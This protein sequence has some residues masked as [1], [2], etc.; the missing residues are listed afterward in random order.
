MEINVL[1]ICDG[2]S[3]GRIAL[4]RA[5][6]KVGNYYASEIDKYAIQVTQANYPDTIQ[7]GDMTGWRD[8]DIDWKSIGMVQSGTPCQGFS[9]AGKQ[10]AFDDPRSKLFFVFVEIL[11]HVQS[12]NPS[13]LFLLENVRMKEEH[14]LVISRTLGINPIVI[15]SAL[16]SAQSRLRLYW[17]NFGLVPDGMF[18]EMKIG[19]PQPK[20]KG[21]L[22]RDVLESEVEEKY[23]LSGKAVTGILQHKQNQEEKG[24][25]FGAVIKG[26]DDLVKV[27]SYIVASRG[28]NPENPSDITTGASLEQRL[29][30]RTDGKTN[31][32]T[33]VQKDN[34]VMQLNPSKESN[35]VQPYQQNRVY[36]PDGISPALSA[37]L[38]SG[39]HLIQVGNIYDNEHNSVAGRVYTDEGK[40]VTLS[41][42]GGGGG[43]KTGL[44]NIEHRI[45]R[46]TP[47]ECERLQTV[48]EGYTS[49]VSDTQRY[50]ILGNGW[51]IDVVS[52]IFS[53][54]NHPSA[55]ATTPT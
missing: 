48:P 25:G 43:A 11:R 44:Y 19:I 21:I 9:F 15:N 39:S 42:L 26:V 53:F 5:G 41:A 17:C 8:W 55:Q 46:L 50:R 10:L 32:L 31:T 23:Y 40:S 14:E 24:F 16:L 7:L 2:M 49:Q 47:V 20:D 6:I 1:S 3:C 33:S 37:Q 22:L 4:E 38:S 29:E 30:P 27:E 54:I 12:F 51:T 52:Y 36:S 34:M 18:G 28:R 35:G 45:R 13:V